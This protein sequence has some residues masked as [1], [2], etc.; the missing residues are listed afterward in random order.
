MVT[1]TVIT[2]TDINMLAHM[3][4]ATMLREISQTLT[5]SRKGTVNIPTV[6][7]IAMIMNERMIWKMVGRGKLR[8]KLLMMN[9]MMMMKKI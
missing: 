2:H 8:G 5:M 1:G 4:T 3:G 6:M 9:V 7:A